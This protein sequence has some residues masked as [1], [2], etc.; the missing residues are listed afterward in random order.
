VVLIFCHSLLILVLIARSLGFVLVILILLLLLWIN[1]VASLSIGMIDL[2]FSGNPYTWSNH[3]Q[4]H[5]LIKERL[6]RGIVSSTWLHAFPAISDTHLPDYTSDH[7]PLLLDTAIPSP[8]L[9]RPF[10]FEEF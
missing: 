2:G 10:R 7:N 5:G 9:S 8:S 4:G 6:D 1:W 3:R